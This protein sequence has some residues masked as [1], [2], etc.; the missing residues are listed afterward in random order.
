VLIDPADSLREVLLS[1]FQW[2][3][4]LIN[5]G[6]SALVGG[7]A[8]FMGMSNAQALEPWREQALKAADRFAT[9]IEVLDEALHEAYEHQSTEQFKKAI[10]D[11]H[12]I[13][14]VVEHFQGALPSALFP[15]LC[16][17]TAHMV[18]DL[19]AVRLDL[20]NLGLQSNPQVVQTWNQMA[21]VYNN[22]IYPIFR[23][24]PPHS[25]SG[26]GALDIL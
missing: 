10:E 26:R 6:K 15:E 19:Q 24:C 20:I 22:E 4:N 1:Y 23:A 7:L 18:E 21:G 11:I 2:E 16:Q 12:H 13:E 3:A 9:S 14:K 17:D 25:W 8:L 5:F